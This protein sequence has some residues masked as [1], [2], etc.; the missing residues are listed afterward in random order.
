MIDTHM[1]RLSINNGR[2]LDFGGGSGVFLP[3]LSQ[4]FTHVTCI[5]IE[6]S[7]AEKV[8]YKYGLNNVTVIEEDI[9]KVDYSTSKFDAIVAADVL[10][11]FFHLEE[12]VETIRAWLSPEGYLF[13]SLPTENWVYVILRKFFGFEKPEDHYHKAAEVEL[14][15]QRSGFRAVRRTYLPFIIPFASLFII[16]A[17]KFR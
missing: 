8:C 17:W 3:T 16:T 6:S 14:F 10:E 11:H 4:R 13:T 5:D 7:D 2:C 15:L 9:R 1:S 12:P